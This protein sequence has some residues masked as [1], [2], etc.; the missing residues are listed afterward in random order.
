MGTGVDVGVVSVCVVVIPTT[1]ACRAHFFL[2]CSHW[3]WCPGDVSSRCPGSIP[4]KQANG[5]RSMLSRLL[6][7]EWYN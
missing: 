6:C 3:L 5:S 1:S 7:H 2:V 4:R